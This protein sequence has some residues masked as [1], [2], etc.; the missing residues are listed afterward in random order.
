MAADLRSR[1]IDLVAPIGIGDEIAPGVRLVDASTE[2]GLRLSFALDGDRILHLEI[3]PIEEMRPCAA[4]SARLS[5]AY[6]ADVDAAQIDERVALSLCEAVAARARSHEEAVLAQ[7][8]CDAAEAR[9]SSD[10]ATRVR[11]VEVDRLLER[12]G[13]SDERY[14][15][16]SPYVGCLVGCR[17][18]YA[19]EKVASVRRLEQLPDVAWGSFVDVRVNA[20]DVLAREL[21]T[22]PP[23]PIKF[24]PIVS[25]P[26]HAVEAR[27]KLTAKCLDVLAREATPRMVMLLTRARLIARD[28]ARIAALPL[29]FAGMSIPTIDDDVRL[30]FEPRAASIAERLATLRTLRDAGA[31]T[32]AVVQPILPGSIEAL[33]DALASVV[34][35][36][37]IDVLHGVHGA[38]SEFADPTY[39]MT[40]SDAWQRERA[41]ELTAA[42]QARSVAVWPGELPAPLH[43][44]NRNR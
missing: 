5:F 30:H 2:L 20:A 34:S 9:A 17:F 28:A 11:L 18:C 3:A 42:L 32:F 36:V 25:D 21:E 26:Y 38:A 37:R 35:S 13:S 14:L 23:W 12:A 40:A 10:G 43:G 33:A 16:I 19:Q 15:T 27:F 39:A 29:G 6:R 4:K 41:R 44:L 8:A 1:L 31:R 22:A 7:I 24:C